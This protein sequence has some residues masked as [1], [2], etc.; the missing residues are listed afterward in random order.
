MFINKEKG[1]AV[2]KE[3]FLQWPEFALNPFVERVVALELISR[4][5]REVE[6]QALKE[7]EDYIKKESGESKQV[8]STLNDTKAAKD[9]GK[10]KP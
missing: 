2:D 4:R 5:K 9:T 8:A 6:A 3:I 7:K 1:G 10:K